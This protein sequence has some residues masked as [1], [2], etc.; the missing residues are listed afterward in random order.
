MVSNELLMLK[1]ILS[2]KSSYEEN[3]M[4][5]NYNNIILD[6]D[7]LIVDVDITIPEEVSWISPELDYFAYDILNDKINLLGGGLNVKL[8][9]ISVNGEPISDGDMYLTKKDEISIE[10]SISGFITDK[11][12]HHFFK[13]TVDFEISFHNLFDI[14]VT[15]D[16]LILNV[17]YNIDK[18]IIKNFNKDKKIIITSITQD[19]AE[20]IYTWLTEDT[21][22]GIEE[23][24]I[25]LEGY[26]YS[27]IMSDIFKIN[28][29]DQTYLTCYL[30]PTKICGKTIEGYVGGETDP[31][32][33]FK[34]L[35]LKSIN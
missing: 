2:H 12:T 25:G 5:F 31:K 30:V 1:K 11:F 10:K 13:F 21:D 9:V 27:G 7:F 32:D 29:D 33:Y 23:I 14:E 20:S 22:S 15:Y 8:G 28:Q 26:L 19:L 3:G 24:R 17:G 18:I 6:K 35:I 16:Q 4:I 34:E